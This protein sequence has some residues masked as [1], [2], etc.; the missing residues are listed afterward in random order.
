MLFVKCSLKGLSCSTF[1]AIVHKKFIENESCSIL[2][3]ELLCETTMD[4][5]RSFVVNMVSCEEKVVDKFLFGDDAPSDMVEGAI[6]DVKKKVMERGGRDVVIVKMEKN[7]EG[8]DENDY[9][10]YVCLE[11]LD[12]PCPV[13]IHFPTGHHMPRAVGI[14][15]IQRQQRERLARIAT[16]LCVKCAAIG[17]C[18]DGFPLLIEEAKK[19][20]RTVRPTLPEE[21]AA[22]QNEFN[23]ARIGITQKLMGRIRRVDDFTPCN[24]ELTEW[25]TV[26][27]NF[28][29]ELFSN[30]VC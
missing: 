5:R 14:G 19:Q 24:N 26:I 2:V 23:T 18:F 21:I 11:D 13:P 8:I 27:F 6:E 17:H 16:V 10:L 4:D 20:G 30:P 3:I 29:K 9:F 12:E 1:C 7:D 28:L 25:N 22:K 15:E